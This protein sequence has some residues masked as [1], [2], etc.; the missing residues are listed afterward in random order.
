MILECMEM[1]EITTHKVVLYKLGREGVH[2]LS[3]E[4]YGWVDDR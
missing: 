3:Q 2:I 4:E 1:S